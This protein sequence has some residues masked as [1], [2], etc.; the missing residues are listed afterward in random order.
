MLSRMETSQNTQ[1][2]HGVPAVE[3]LTKK[4]LAKRLRV[5]ERKIEMHTDLPRIRWGRN[6]RFD[7]QEVVEFLRTQRA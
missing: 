7:W 6:V 3:L 1:S 4:E 2:N 5:S